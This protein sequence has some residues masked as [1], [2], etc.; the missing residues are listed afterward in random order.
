MKIL[1]EAEKRKLEED[2]MKNFG[3][4]LFL[5]GL[6]LLQAGE[7]RIRVTTP[8]TIEM[9]SK[10]RGFVSAGLYIAKRS[11]HFTTLTI[12]GCNFLLSV[13]KGYV[14]DLDKEGALQWM[15]GG[16]VDVGV[17]RKLILGRY[18]NFFLG[19]AIVDVNGKAYPQVPTW[20]RIPIQTD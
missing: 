14:V 8:E 4:K 11:K 19:T 2:V 3:S 18:R 12:E 13:D 5:E 17:R 6:V 10:L 16:P 20:R 15:K 7:N 9:M 1:S